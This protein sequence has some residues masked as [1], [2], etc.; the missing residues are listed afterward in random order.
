MRGYGESNKPEDGQTH[1]NYSKRAMVRDGIEVMEH[2]D[3]G[4][5]AWSGTDRG[6]R[7]IN[8]VFRRWK[9]TCR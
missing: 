3:T 2:W 9:L 8:G 5:S 4:S 6:A 1:S 7:R